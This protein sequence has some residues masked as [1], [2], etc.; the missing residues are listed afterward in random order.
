M[1]IDKDFSRNVWCILGL[2]FDAVTL[3]QA[4]QEIL[5]AIEQK[6][7]CFLSTPNLNFL[8]GTQTD[9]AF[10][11]SVINSDLSVADGFPIVVVAKMLNIPISERVAGSDLIENLHQRTTDNPVKVFFFGGE[12]GAGER[13]SAAVNQAPSG[14]IAVGHFAPGFGSVTEMS[15]PD[16]IANVNQHDIDFLI[17]SLGAKKGQ[18]WIEQNKHLLKATVVSHLGAVVNF[19]AGTVLRAPLL[20]QRT[21]LEWLWRIYQEPALWRRYYN[22]GKIFAGMLFTRVLPYALWLRV[23]KAADKDKTLTIDTQRKP[24]QIEFKLSGNCYVDTLSPLRSA[25]KAAAQENCDVSIDFTDA[26]RID[27]AFLGLC[28]ILY[29][30]LHASGRTLRFTNVNPTLKR[31]I[32]WHNLSELIA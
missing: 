17:V 31:I 8:C 30:Y 32:T 12:P 27:S 21:G 25:F 23:N 29:K 4:A 9:P 16:I 10:R 2:P 22:D 5:T 6:Q 3:Q 14:L 28:L 11:Q 15:S 18:A 7:P 24:G 13:A 20:M 19:F 1:T 26:G